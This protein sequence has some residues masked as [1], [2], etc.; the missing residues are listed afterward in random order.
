MVEGLHMLMLVEEIT[1][2]HYSLVWRFLLGYGSK[3][4]FH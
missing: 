4:F 1:I 3:K 2:V